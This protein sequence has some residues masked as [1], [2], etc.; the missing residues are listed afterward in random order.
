MPPIDPLVSPR[1]ALEGRVVTMNERFDVE[2]VGRVYVDASRIVAVQPADAPP[3]MGLEDVPVVRTGGT[4]YP[5]LIEL[6]NHLSYNALPAWPIGERFENRDQ[7]GRRATYRQLISRPAAI[8]GSTEG[9]VQAVVRYVEAKCLLAGVTT[10][11]GIALASNAGIRRFYRGIVRNVEHTGDPDLP[12]SSTRIADVEA[13]DAGKFRT[14]LERGQTV[15]LHLSEGLDDRARGHFHAL[16]TSE[17]DWAITPSLGGIHC[18]GLRDT[19][20]A[21]FAGHG[22]SMVWSPLSNLILYGGTADIARARREGV[23]VALGS[24]WAPS[25][26][27]NL[28]GE[29][30]VAKLVNETAG[31]VWTSREIVAM[32][33]INAARIVKWHNEL[34]SIE[35]HKRADLIVVD[36]RLGDPYDQ[37]IAARETSM[38]LVI[39]NGIPRCGTRQLM[40]AFDGHTETLRIGDAL[41]VLNLAQATGDPL[42]GAISVAE[43]QERLVD[44]LAHLPDMDGPGRSLERLGARE[45]DGGAER[46]ERWFIDLDHAARD[47]TTIRLRPGGQGEP[48]DIEGPRDAATDLPL[49]PLRPDPL[50][51]AA[52][53]RFDELVEGQPNLPEHVKRGLPRFY[54]A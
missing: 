4:I 51:V 46:N 14:R 7:W 35:P 44:A 12:A 31:D 8:L 3:P 36:G 37:L 32:A 54:G 1:Y 43:A 11:Q 10:T 40:A 52:D 41:R 53:A 47:G 22:G 2:G 15:L 17:G 25:G 21:T 39:I 26:S 16:Q 19:D 13:R 42:V 49:I 45:V 9:L 20:Y 34:G 28:L 30:K 24:D 38:S 5:G 50:T 33:T 18:C 6:H 27:R 48:R 29:M 23:T